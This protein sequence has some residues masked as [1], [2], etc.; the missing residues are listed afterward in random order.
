[1]VGARSLRI[2]KGAKW[3]PLISRSKP[4]HLKSCFDAR[5][6]NHHPKRA[7]GWLQ[8]VQGQQRSEG[9]DPAGRGA[10]PERAGEQHRQPL[11]QDVFRRTSG[12]SAWDTDRKN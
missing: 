8:R 12:W 2:I 11:N 4:D 1:M 10:E 7:R 9:N 6:H 3:T 5:R